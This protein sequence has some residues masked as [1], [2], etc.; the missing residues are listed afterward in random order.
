MSIGSNNF[1]PIIPPRSAPPASSIKRT[2]QEKQP[3]EPLKEKPLEVKKNELMKSPSSRARKIERSSAVREEAIQEEEK[4]IQIP[5][6]KVN[7]PKPLP[8]PPSPRGLNPTRRGLDPTFSKRGLAFSKRDDQ[9]PTIAGSDRSSSSGSGKTAFS[10]SDGTPASA[11]QEEAISN[12]VI[13]K[14]LADAFPTV[15]QTAGAG[16]TASVNSAPLTQIELTAELFKKMVKADPKETGEEK[17]GR[18]DKNIS[19]DIE[20]LFG[21]KMTM[22]T[23]QLFEG[24]KEA[25]NETESREDKEKYVDFAISWVNSNLYPEDLADPDIKELLNSLTNGK[26]DNS[27]RPN[28][29][30][31]LKGLIETGK[32]YKNPVA[33]Q[34]AVLLKRYERLDDPIS[35][36]GRL[37]DAILIVSKLNA[38]ELDNPNIKKIIQ[39]F[40][41]KGE[42]KEEHPNVVEAARKL[43]NTSIK[44]S[45]CNSLNDVIK[46]CKK[47]PAAVAKELGDLLASI[48][49]ETT[50]SSLLATLNADD[51]K[52]PIAKN[53]MYMILAFKQLSSAISQDILDQSNKKDMLNR[54]AFYLQVANKLLESN[55][56]GTLSAVVNALNVSPIVRL[57][58]VKSKDKII[59][60]KLIQTISSE[61]NFKMFRDLYTKN[62]ESTLTFLLNKELI[63]V[64]EGN[65]KAKNIQAAEGNPK[66]INKEL[67]SIR[68][69]YIADMIKTATEH[70][71][72]MK[73]RKPITDLNLTTLTTDSE[74]EWYTKSFKF[75]P[76]TTAR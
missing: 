30:N 74:D 50:I 34:L 52:T 42:V 20:I 5:S 53:G 24:L 11:K 35:K 64:A 58:P 21:Y 17:K 62:P 28:N 66:T 2:E 69:A 56:A 6:S 39:S 60:D 9:E 29:S 40:I 13:E 49:S 18:L 48:Q 7:S 22:G 19:T 31:I 23:K 71:D 76:S 27:T 10:G 65:P 72:N 41:D 15:N 67:N 8:H 12:V 1:N 61:K 37:N 55:D 38:R 32:P 68:I 36:V 16:A 44:N 4:A 54:H 14:A 43:R 57:D 25:Y 46:K 47:D 45:E 75:K 63:Q 3:T 26:T 70:Q 73:N 51:Q 33:Q 59:H